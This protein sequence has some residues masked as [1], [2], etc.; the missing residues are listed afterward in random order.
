MVVERQTGSST[1]Q[2][3]TLPNPSST[4][5]L[6]II[7]QTPFYACP[8]SFCLVVTLREKPYFN[9]KIVKHQ[10]HEEG[11]NPTMSPSAKP[12]G[13]CRNQWGYSESRVHPWCCAEGEVR[14][15]AGHDWWASSWGLSCD[16]RVVDS[17]NI[18]NL[19]LMRTLEFGMLIKCPVI[20][21]LLSF[22]RKRPRR[23]WYVVDRNHITNTILQ[24]RLRRLLAYVSN[25]DFKPWSEKGDLEN[26]DLLLNEV[27]SIKGAKWW[28][29]QQTA[30]CLSTLLDAPSGVV[31]ATLSL[32]R[33][34]AVIAR[35][36]CKT[37]LGCEPGIIT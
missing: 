18:S 20:V 1:T 3:S 24:M 32:S 37:M 9:P 34:L 8:F 23:K 10:W 29:S 27:V 21:S 14:E 15:H 25:E 30:K 16:S 19:L 22:F 17:K 13:V 11:T 4:T 36:C 12:T 5:T 35:K 28:T 6:A 2:Q 7:F 31:Y 26:L 33:H